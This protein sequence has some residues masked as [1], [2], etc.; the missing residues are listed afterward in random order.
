MDPA[1]NS[2]SAFFENDHKTPTGLGP[3][4]RSQGVTRVFLAGLAL[5]FCVR[6]SAQDA[7]QKASRC[8]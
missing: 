5:D 1:I 8:K 6:W 2:Y 7:V 3:Y 4:L